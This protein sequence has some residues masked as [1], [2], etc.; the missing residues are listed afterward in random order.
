MFQAFVI[1]LREGLEAFLII[2]ISLAY[3]RKSGRHELIPAVHWGIAVAIALSVAAGMAFQRAAN[4]ALWEGVL[5]IVAAVMVASLTIHMWRVAKHLEGNIE[6]RLEETSMRP[7]AWAMLGV[8]GFTLL[9]ITREGMETAL[10]MNA[11]LF[12][13]RSAQLV[14]GATA[15]ILCAASVAWLW[16]RY[17]HR[18]NLARFF[19][20]TAIFL[21][22]FV[23]QLFVYG[24]H[25]L[26]EANIFPY[27]EPLHWATEPYGPDGRYGQYL[28]YLLVLLPVTW[29][30]YA[31]WRE[32]H[33]E[34][35]AGR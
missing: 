34:V 7:G 14:A 6:E 3:L 11:L 29:L 1:T 32:R 18:V 15:G 9:M 20:V 28:T 10:L 2:A 23:A 27:S 17:G 33:V 19:Q 12:Q 16:S 25:E 26:T 13:V 22:V 21:L 35:I 31:S 4:Q 24:F 5:A 30:A 8:F